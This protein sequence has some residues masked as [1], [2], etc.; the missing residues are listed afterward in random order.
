MRSL[1]RNK[2]KIYYALYDSK[3]ELVDADGNSTGEY[4]TTYSTPVAF[5][6]NVSAANGMSDLS[7]FGIND[8]YTKT[9]T[10][11]DMQ[12]PI[13]ETSRLWIGIPTTQP[14]NY[15]VTKVAKSL[16][17]ITYAIKKVDVNA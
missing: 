17:S 1:E 4:V 9:I 3:T 5:R 11:N 13:T 7:P 12:C 2:Q 15:V 6:C 8:S 10:T 14:Y 16:N